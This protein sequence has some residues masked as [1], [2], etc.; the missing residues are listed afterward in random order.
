MIVVM[1]R[2][3]LRL[4]AAL[5]DNARLTNS[6]L[7]ERIGLSPSQCSRRRS[8]LEQAGVIRGYCAELSAPALGLKLLAFVQVRLA[9]HSGDNAEKFRALVALREEVQEAYSVTGKT[10][11]LLKVVVPDLEALSAFVNTVLLRH[12]SVARV[13]SSLVMNRLKETARLPL[14]AAAQP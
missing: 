5:Q 2:F 9:A 6:E 12:E 10:D 3:D 14:R 7:G 8:L 4:L 1:D 11:Y 13:R